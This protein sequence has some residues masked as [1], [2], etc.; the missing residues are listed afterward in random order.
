MTGRLVVADDE[1][2]F[3]THQRVNLPL[4]IDVQ[5]D[6]LEQAFI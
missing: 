1:Q 2:R 5:V 4:L 6:G 3:Q